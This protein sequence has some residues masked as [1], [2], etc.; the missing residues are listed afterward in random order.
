MVTWLADLAYMHVARLQT[1]A[2]GIVAAELLTPSAERPPAN[3]RAARIHVCWLWL[4]RAT[5]VGTAW[6]R[7]ATCTTLGGWLGGWLGGRLGGWVAEQRMPPVPVRNAAMAAA[8]ASC[9]CATRERLGW[10]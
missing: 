2:G 10:W 7:R 6:W 9:P 4:G 3:C 8:H 1:G 5:T